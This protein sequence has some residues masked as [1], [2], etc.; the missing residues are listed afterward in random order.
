MIL[1]MNRATASE[2]MIWLTWVVSQLEPHSIIF[3]PMLKDI[4]SPAVNGYELWRH[5][6]FWDNPKFWG[7]DEPKLLNPKMNTLIFKMIKFKGPIGTL[8][9]DRCSH[10]LVLHVGQ[11]AEFEHRSIFAVA[12]QV[13]FCTG[14]AGFWGGTS[15]T[16]SACQCLHQ[17]RLEL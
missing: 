13:A 16:K 4:I 7:W 1:D 6:L 10:S 12:L 3:Y 17:A 5:P 8:W 2:L 11:P 15:G 14:L 9:L